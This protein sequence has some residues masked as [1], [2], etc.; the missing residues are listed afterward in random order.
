[1]TKIATKQ[2]ASKATI[3]WD[4]DESRAF[5]T[6]KLASA[7][8]LW[9]FIARTDGREQSL[10]VARV[11]HVLTAALESADARVLDQLEHAARRADKKASAVV[12][13]RNA[14]LLELLEF[15][16]WQAKQ[17]KASARSRSEWVK[18]VPIALAKAVLDGLVDVG[19][20]NLA[21]EI[22]RHGGGTW[23]EWNQRTAAEARVAHALVSPLPSSSEEVIRRALVALG[24]PGTKA[25]NLFSFLDK[26]EKRSRP[27]GF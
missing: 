4:S 2:D 18:G 16:E 26:R 13:P 23:L 25:K 27:S 8:A 5:A 22:R 6:A 17:H 9:S 12:E 14:A 10:A 19:A 20:A 7:A 11:L 3:P 15:V 1:M 21:H 24:M